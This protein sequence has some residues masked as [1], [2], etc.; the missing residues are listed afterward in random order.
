MDENGFRIGCISGRIV[1]T[2]IHK[3]AVYLAD[4][5]NRE[6]NTVIECICADGSTIEPI[7]NLK[8][9]VLLETHFDNS[10]TKHC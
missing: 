3:K 5:D 7:L 10:L 6:S 2:H 4:P 8:G 9:E 1:I